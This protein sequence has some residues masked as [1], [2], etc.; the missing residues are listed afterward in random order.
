MLTPL[1]IISID[2][3]LASIAETECLHWSCQ[4]LDISLLMLAINRYILKAH[5]LGPE[6]S[7]LLALTPVRA[8]FSRDQKAMSDGDQEILGRLAW[9]PETP[10]DSAGKKRHD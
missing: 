8:C 3:L 9:S 2:R 7:P 4:N 10:K 6:S 1:L 5:R